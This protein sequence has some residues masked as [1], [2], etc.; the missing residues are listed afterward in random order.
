MTDAEKLR[1][2]VEDG[3]FWG[4]AG[5]LGTILVAEIKRLRAERDV[6]LRMFAKA[7]HRGPWTLTPAEWVALGRR[8]AGLPEAEAEP[9]GEP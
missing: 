9:K 8:M 6:A 7:R 1:R 3:E 2:A 4:D 5:T